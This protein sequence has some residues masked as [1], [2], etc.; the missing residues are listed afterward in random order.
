MIEGLELAISWHRREA[1]EC[2]ARKNG[3]SIGIVDSQ[4]ETR[5]KWHDEAAEA[6]TRIALS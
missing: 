3:S 4:L 2:R 6:L 5:A 1:A